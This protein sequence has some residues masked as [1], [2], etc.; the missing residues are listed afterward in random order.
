MIILITMSPPIGKISQKILKD[1][2]NVL[3][4][5]EGR[6]SVYLVGGYVRDIL[7]GA[8]SNDRDY[9][10]FG[11]SSTFVEGIQKITG[12][13]IVAFKKRTCFGLH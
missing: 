5:R 1:Q 4:F 6:G 9:V 12:G 3:V 13:T 7:I 10:F 8:R 2:Y 11:N